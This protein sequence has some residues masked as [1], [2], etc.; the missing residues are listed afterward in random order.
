MEH[1]KKILHTLFFPHWSIVCFCLTVSLAGL[2]YVFLNGLDTQPFSYAVYGFSFYSLCIL[3][4]SAPTLYKKAH[5]LAHSNK[6]TDKYLTEETVRIRFSLYSGTVIN[7]LYAVYKLVLGF[8][9]HSVWFGAEG[10]Y[11]LVLCL[12]RFLQVCADR[13]SNH[14][15]VSST[16]LSRW[17]RFRT[18]GFLLI[19]LNITMSGLIV[20]LLWENQSYTYPSFVIYAA[21]AYTFYRL[22]MAII[23]T[24]KLHKAENPIYTAARAM[25]LCAALMA[26]LALQTAMFSAF[27]TDL[28][29]ETQ[30]L[31]NTLT[32]LGVSISVMAI[33]VIM[34]LRA[35]KAIR[36]I[37][38]YPSE[39]TQ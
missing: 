20:Q 35:Q 18:C 29:I 13:K 39:D 5:A 34:L 15:D 32:G 28:D 27:G 33:A 26:V 37:K 25:D 14:S 31:M 38:K 30:N 24:V 16:L 11:Y 10:I 8:I 9:Y 1:W 12:I 7:F 21:A 2:C 22:T 19:L 23:H 36:T 3:A 6:I 17:L 4:A